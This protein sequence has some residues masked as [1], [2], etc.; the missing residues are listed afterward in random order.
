MRLRNS[1]TLRPTQR[2]FDSTRFNSIRFDSEYRIELCAAWKLNFECKLALRGLP[3][4]T[5]AA[6]K[7]QKTN[8]P[9]GKLAA[10]VLAPA[11][12][13]VVISLRLRVCVCACVRYLAFFAPLWTNSLAAACRAS[14]SPAA[15]VVLVAKLETRFGAKPNKR[16]NEQTD[17]RTDRQ[18]DRQTDKQTNK[19]TNRQTRKRR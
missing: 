1:R 2:R 10:C 8:S 18:T 9:R 15:V 6:N 16:T 12:A 4:I 11:V 7:A 14:F 13:V 3:S 17:G 5:A 19:Q